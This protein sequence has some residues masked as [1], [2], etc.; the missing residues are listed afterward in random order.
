M[1]NT[2]KAQ[3]Q[4]LSEGQ[5]ERMVRTRISKWLE[6]AATIEKY[7]TPELLKFSI[8][9]RRVSKARTKLEELLTWFQKAYLAIDDAEWDRIIS[10][11]VSDKSSVEHNVTVVLSAKR[12]AHSLNFSRLEIAVDHLIQKNPT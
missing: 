5:I 8:N 1:S 7:N 11:P 12:V 2:V 4:N 10:Q 6:H 3:F 9:S